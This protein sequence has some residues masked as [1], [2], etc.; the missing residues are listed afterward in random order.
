MPQEE[1]RPPEQAHLELL[2]E[3]EPHRGGDLRIEEPL[4]EVGRDARLGVVGQRRVD[5]AVGLAA[6]AQLAV[7]LTLVVQVGLRRV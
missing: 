1:R 5:G 7:E 6:E 4:L 3:D 2:G